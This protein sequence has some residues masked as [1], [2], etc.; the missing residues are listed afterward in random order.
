MLE[1]RINALCRY[2]RELIVSVLSRTKCTCFVEFCRGL[3]LT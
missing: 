2:A 1:V 3:A